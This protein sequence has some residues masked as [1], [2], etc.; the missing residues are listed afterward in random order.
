MN[1]CLIVQ[2][3]SVSQTSAKASGDFLDTGL[4]YGEV[5]ISDRSKKEEVTREFLEKMDQENDAAVTTLQAVEE[6]WFSHLGPAQTGI[7]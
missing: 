2:P 7:K 1:S 4:G 5:M 6:T 3:T